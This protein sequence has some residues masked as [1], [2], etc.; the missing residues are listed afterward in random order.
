MD[1]EVE[2]KEPLDVLTEV[3]I[4]KKYDKK[5]SSLDPA[6]F[7]PKEKYNGPPTLIA[8]QEP[9]LSL[10]KLRHSIHDIEKGPFM[11]IQKIKE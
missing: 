11:G 1:I 10:E 2:L 5:S 7:D 4:K 3:A 6:S 9:M 8:E